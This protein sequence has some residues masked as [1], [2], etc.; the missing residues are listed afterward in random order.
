MTTCSGFRPAALSNSE[1][2]KLRNDKS[3]S[4]A[5]QHF[6]RANRP[7]TSRS[8][9]WDEDFKYD[10]LLSS[11]ND[12]G[13]LAVAKILLSPSLLD[14]P[15]GLTALFASHRNVGW[16]IQIDTTRKNTNGMRTMNTPANSAVEISCRSKRTAQRMVVAIPTGN[17]NRK[18]MRA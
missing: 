2:C 9:T 4:C 13:N 6:A 15:L 17:I 16:P 1:C 3:M 18:A 8:G 14:P 7:I 5:Q 10:L 12:Q 11:Q